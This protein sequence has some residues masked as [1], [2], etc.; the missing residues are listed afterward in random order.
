MSNHRPA[1]TLHPPRTAVRNRGDATRG[2]SAGGHGERT[3]R[4]SLARPPEAWALGELARG[5]DRLQV[6]HKRD[7]RQGDW[8]VVTTRNSVYSLLALGDGNYSVA[9]G[10]FDRQQRSPQRVGVNGC[11]FGGQAL[12]FDVL[13]GPGLFLEFANQVTTT[14]IQKVEVFHCDDRG[15]VH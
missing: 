7:L 10:W 5:V 1:R 3:G 4:T 9:G 11:T 6:V 14:R 8:I 12:K 15:P 2:D 13:A